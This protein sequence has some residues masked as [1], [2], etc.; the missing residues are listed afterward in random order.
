MH[1]KWAETRAARELHELNLAFLMLLRR[2]DPE[3]PAF[4]L[5][6]TSWGQLFRLSSTQLEIIAGMPCLLAGFAGQPFPASSFPASARFPESGMGVAETAPHHLHREPIRPPAGRRPEPGQRPVPCGPA[7]PVPER[8]SSELRLYVVGL[9]TWLWQ[10]ARQDPLLATLC[11][12][13]DCSVLDGL[14]QM[15]FGEIQRVGAAATGLLE[16]RF[17]RYPRLWPDLLRAARTRNPQVVVVTQLSVAQLTLVGRRPE[18]VSAGGMQRR[19]ELRP[20][21]RLPNRTGRRPDS[22]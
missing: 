3:R 12:G 8:H 16:A 22:G 15:S 17:C 6:G 14:G 20:A 11:M 19:V 18:L 9:I 5:D 21:G 1:G 2:G 4:G 10:T 7:H 13:P